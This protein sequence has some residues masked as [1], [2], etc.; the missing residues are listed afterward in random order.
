MKKLLISITLIFLS[1]NVNAEISRNGIDNIKQLSWSEI[2][3]TVSETYQYS[4][5]DA[6]H[7]DGL[8]FHPLEERYGK[9]SKQN[10]GEYRERVPGFNYGG[11]SVAEQGGTNKSWSV[12]KKNNQICYGGKYAEHDCVYLFE[13]LENSKKYFYFSYSKNGD[14]YAKIN[15]LI[16]FDTS[17]PINQ[18]FKNLNW[19]YVYKNSNKINLV[20]FTKENNLLSKNINDKENVKWDALSPEDKKIAEEKIAAD[21]GYSSY[22]EMQ[23][24]KKV[25]EKRIAEEKIVADRKRIDAKKAENL[26]D[27]YIDYLIIKNIYDGAKYYVNSSQM[28]Q[29][30]AITIATENYYKNSITS[31]DIVWQRA[32]N[33]YEREWAEYIATMKST[34]YNTSFSGFTD[35]KMIGIINRASKNGISISNTV[36]DF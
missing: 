34:S 32:V 26:L 36:K 5:V 10:R 28:E 35:L 31:S 20:V 18:P 16:K 7:A 33:F 8:N 1:L 25:E 2:V 23:S 12:D 30:K 29:V 9:L 24:A 22:A 13:G 17:K 19:K 3:K 11:W 15:R 27:T 14:F 6:V 21:A 4:Y